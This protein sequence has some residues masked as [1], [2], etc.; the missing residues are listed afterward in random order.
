MAR[1]FIST[2]NYNALNA[3]YGNVREAYRRIHGRNVI[4]AVQISVTVIEITYDFRIIVNDPFDAT[5]IWE[6]IDALSDR[7][8]ALETKVE[9]IDARLTAVETGD[10]GKDRAATLVITLGDQPQS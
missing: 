5:K 2:K 10:D 7:M 3:Q 9:S 8:E 1:E 6:A 4:N